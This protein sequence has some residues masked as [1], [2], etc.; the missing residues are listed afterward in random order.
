M[1]EEDADSDIEQDIKN[2]IELDALMM[3]HHNDHDEEIETLKDGPLFQDADVRD[4][5]LSEH[6]QSQDSPLF[7]EQDEEKLIEAV[8][9]DVQEQEPND[10]E[11]DKN[12]G[13]EDTELGTQTVE[14]I[15]PNPIYS[16]SATDH[17]IPEVVEN[18]ESSID[19][20][21][22]INDELS[23]IEKELN[24]HHD[25]TE[26]N[27]Y[28]QLSTDPA[29]HQN[30]NKE[31]IINEPHNIEDDPIQQNNEIDVE[32]YLENANIDDA[33]GDNEIDIEEDKQSDN[34]NLED[35]KTENPQED[36]NISN[37]I[38]NEDQHIGQISDEHYD[39]IDTIVN[40]ITTSDLTVVGSLNEDANLQ[41]NN[42]LNFTSATPSPQIP[43]LTM[44]PY[45]SEQQLAE[46]LE[47][48][49]LNDNEI[50]D[51]MLDDGWNN[52]PE[53]MIDEDIEIEQEL[54]TNQVSKDMDINDLDLNV[55]IDIDQD[56]LNDEMLNA[57]PFED[58]NMMEECKQTTIVEQLQLPILN[59][60]DMEVLSTVAKSD[61]NMQNEAK[62]D[63]KNDDIDDLDVDDLNLDDGWGQDGIEV[64]NDTMF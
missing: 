3:A 43:E 25:T 33:W 58:E 13:D 64:D 40:N 20:N 60:D 8:N 22:E 23:K 36:H 54:P 18:E 59:S 46:N 2:E 11:K 42:E 10:L 19:V 39:P 12:I 27:H 4:L 49:K 61:Q 28:E 37:E 34:A 47:E 50:G 41:P 30:E 14:Q 45:E 38:K 16:N 24:E 57:D 26:N 55:D 17:E 29:Q 51:I 53:L 1:L 35:E 32:Q 63:P 5:N 31:V 6:S 62:T 9:D 21:H 15:Q 44:D 48:D 52:D 56:L 7:E